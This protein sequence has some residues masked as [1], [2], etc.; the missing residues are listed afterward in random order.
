LALKTHA[1]LLRKA[2]ARAPH[3][4]FIIER[5]SAQVGI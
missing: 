3:G 4:V 2:D 1:M 5:E